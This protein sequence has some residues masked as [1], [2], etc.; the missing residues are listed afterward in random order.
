MVSGNWRANVH[1]VGPNSREDHVCKTGVMDWSSH[2]PSHSSSVCHLQKILYHKTTNESDQWGSRAR[3][4]IWWK[5]STSGWGIR[6]PDSVDSCLRTSVISTLGRQ[7]RFA[8]G[9]KK[10]TAAI[11]SNFSEDHYLNYIN[12]PLPQKRWWNIQERLLYF[13]MTLGKLSFLWPS[14]LNS[15]LR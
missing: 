12:I 1:T 4:H 14:H 9:Q 3:R 2:T 13:Q 15:N 6:C 11:F 8:S 5:H 7:G 10:L